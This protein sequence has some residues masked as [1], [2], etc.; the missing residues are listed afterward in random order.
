MQAPHGRPT[1]PPIRKTS[2][3]YALCQLE[4]KSGTVLGDWAHS[5]I[6]TA[7]DADDSSRTTPR[8]AGRHFRFPW[9]QNS[10]SLICWPFTYR[11]NGIKGAV[12]PAS[13]V[14]HQL[15][16]NTQSTVTHF[17]ATSQLP[18]RSSFLDST[19]TMKIS[20]VLSTLMVAGLVAAAPPAER[21]STLHLLKEN[22]ANACR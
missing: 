12:Q 19:I 16:S 8:Q 7:S 4:S 17:P 5:P 14:H 6:V 10:N 9:R 1:D 20:T 2:T 11:W 13:L 21:M 22:M 15:E 3:V 18:I